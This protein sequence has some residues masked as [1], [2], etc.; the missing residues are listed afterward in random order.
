[1]PSLDIFPDEIIRHV[2]LF[3]SPEDT[4]QSIQLLSRRFYHI[5]NE[6]LLWK[7]HC[8]NSFNYWHPDHRLSTK[9]AA[10]ASSVKWK[11][12]WITRKRKNTK[13]ALLLDGILAT[14]VGQLSKLK[15]ICLL[16]YDA[17]DYLLEQCHTDDSADD[18]LA[19]STPARGF[20]D[21]IYGSLWYSLANLEVRGSKHERNLETLCHPVTF[22]L[23][24][25]HLVTNMCFIRYYADS[26][27]DSIHRGIAV[28]VWAEYQGAPLSARGLDRALGAFDMFVL[29]D[30]PQDL[31]YIS[32]SFD[33]LAR[34]FRQ[35]NPRCEEMPTR[36]RALSLVQWLRA[37]N[38]TSMDSPE[39][40]YRNLR[41][42]F[43]GQAL[44]DEAHPSLP[45][46]S[47]AI[48][49]CVAERLGMTSSCCAFP[50]HVHAAVFAPPGMNLDGAEE[51]NPNKELE[52]M[53]LDPY[54]SDY[55]VTPSD[56]RSR[57]VEFGWTLGA[58]AFLKPSP[59]S[60]I[61]QRTAQNI[62]A[63]YTE[64]QT[65]ADREDDIVRDVE[66]KRLRT[67]HPDLN[68]ETAAYAAVWA[69]LMM[70]QTTALH[71]DNNLESFLNRFALSWSED[72]WI[73]EKYLAPLYDRFVR[74]QPNPRPRVGWENVRE[75]LGML[76]NLDN[77]LPTVSR[78]YT[79]EI[80]SRVLYKIGQVFRHKRYQYVGVINGW[81]ANGTAS[82]PTPH[83]L[84]DEDPEE[85]G[86]A[87][88]VDDPTQRARIRS[89]TYYTCLR[90]TIDR[91][92][93]D[94][95][96]IEIITDPSLIPN[97]LFYLAGK[98][99]KKF[100]SSTCT[101]ISNIKEYYPDD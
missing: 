58:D 21:L 2:L 16:G 47:S 3:V 71:W 59:V 74:S 32:E 69:E 42:C 82:L 22:P 67:G 20:L 43:I 61:V 96:N 63:T 34:E 52:T 5:G 4:L 64:V 101:F 86:E 72:A 70:K 19:R 93:V 35:E 75:I 30:Q 92:R 44:S 7:S 46:I 55:E 12:L 78:R 62:K 40:N 1:M 10:R 97:A 66:M 89:K 91:L 81:A 99:F 45:I 13:V 51:E 28:E 15:Q 36:Q 95:D 49:C 11:E 39:R 17:K 76:K 68:L 57:L 29:H 6:A 56:L 27:L 23:P 50:S 88:G 98:F 48:F 53:Y 65:L 73:V 90:P 24:G 85:E 8:Q 37:N 33:R 25:E 84:V 31:E 18:V 60:I 80:H 83:H 14:K 100:N 9:L 79:E 26:V 41:N 77:R 87:S 94:Q 54:S 38:L